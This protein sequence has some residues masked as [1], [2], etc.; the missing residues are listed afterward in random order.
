MAKQA[1]AMPGPLLPGMPAPPFDLADAFGRRHRLASFKGRKLLLL[2]WNSHCGW[3]RKMLPRLKEW[4]NQRENGAAE[5]IVMTQS[6][7]PEAKDMNMK[8]LVLIDGQG[9][10]PVPTPNSLQNHQLKC[11]VGIAILFQ[12]RRYVPPGTLERLFGKVTHR[13]RREIPGLTLQWL[14]C[15]D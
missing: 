3:C 10:R 6:T 7:P 9:Q 13:P 12:P 5:L 15:C 11:H 4:E 8:S 1:A 2:F 14:P